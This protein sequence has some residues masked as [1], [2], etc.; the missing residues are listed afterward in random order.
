MSAAPVVRPALWTS[1][2]WGTAIANKRDRLRRRLRDTPRADRPGRTRL[3]QLLDDLERFW[4]D[5]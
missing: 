3:R 1:K 4:P 2:Q 5:D